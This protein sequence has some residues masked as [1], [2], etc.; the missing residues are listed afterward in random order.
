MKKNKLLYFI[1]S[2]NK[3]PFK[4]ISQHNFYDY[5]YNCL[6]IVRSFLLHPGSLLLDATIEQKIYF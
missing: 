3:I 5:L 1:I 6:D 4:S 2:T